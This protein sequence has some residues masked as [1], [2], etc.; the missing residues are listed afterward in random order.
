[1]W[2]SRKSIERKNEVFEE[3][4]ERKEIKQQENTQ[5]DFHLHYA[6]ALC[7]APCSRMVIFREV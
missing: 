5:I 7:N 1:M 4:E 3:E 6:T 2:K